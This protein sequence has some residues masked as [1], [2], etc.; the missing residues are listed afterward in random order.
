M[1]SEN[2]PTETV[3]VDSSVVETVAV[4]ST[5]PVILPPPIISLVDIMSA[6]EVVV[7]KEKTDKSILN[8]ISSLSYDDLK[9]KLVT[10]ATLGFPNV[11]EIYRLV[12]VPP[13]TCSDGVSRSLTEYIEFCSGKTM[14]AHVES[15]QERVQDMVITFANMGTY[16][17]VVVSKV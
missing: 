10:W 5:I 13:S 17:A 15:L 6:L 2:T 11:Y 14:Q 8:S 9:S 12:I 1:D 16:I 3:L 4:E 7:Q